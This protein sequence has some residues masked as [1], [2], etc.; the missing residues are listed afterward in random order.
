MRLVVDWLEVAVV[1]PVVGVERSVA[2]KFI[3][4]AVKFVAALAG[5]ELDLHRAL[6][7]SIGA[8]GGGRNTDLLDRVNT[9]AD[10]AEKVGV[11]PEQLFLDVD[12]VNHHI[13]RVGR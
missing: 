4:A 11:V 12:A 3:E 5:D 7:R 13:D 2:V 1:K 6:P 9:R 8:R 10:E